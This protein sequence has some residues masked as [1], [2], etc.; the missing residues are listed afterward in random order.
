MLSRSITDAAA[1]KLRMDF[2]SL[3]LTMLAVHVSG[4][5]AAGV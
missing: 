3:E 4:K 5:C 2:N 1:P